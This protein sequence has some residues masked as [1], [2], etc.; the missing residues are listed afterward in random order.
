MRNLNKHAC[1]TIYMNSNY[2]QLLRA[3]IIHTI[4]GI[5]HRN[6]G[7][8]DTQL[9][10]ILNDKLLIDA[11]ERPKKKKNRVRVLKKI[12]FESPIDDLDQ[13]A[14]KRSATDLSR[15]SQEK[16]PRRGGPL[17]A[18]DQYP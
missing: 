9:K 1:M 5:I 17:P 13:N 12:A 8:T 15:A 3:I 7:K 16:Q 14:V 11:L 4:Y 10:A 2:H 18:N 6:M